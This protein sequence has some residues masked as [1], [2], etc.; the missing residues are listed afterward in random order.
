MDQLNT[1]ISDLKPNHI[2][3]CIH[4]V[5][6]CS[7]QQFEGY[8]YSNLKEIDMYVPSRDSHGYGESCYVRTIVPRCCNSVGMV[9]YK[10]WE[11]L[12]ILWISSESNL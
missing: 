1:E 2:S 5:W 12:H 9:G 11:L 7:W 6:N 4:N 10:L 3:S 8:H